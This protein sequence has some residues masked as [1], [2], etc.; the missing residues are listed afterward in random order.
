MT[1]DPL[2]YPI[3]KFDCP[4]NITSEKLEAWISILEHFPERLA[5]LVGNLSEEQLNTRYRPEGW[6]IRQVVHH[7]YDSHHHSY[8]RYKWALTEDTPLIKAYDEAKWAEVFDYVTTP[9]EMS[10]QALSALHRKL[11]FLLKGMK[12]EDFQREYIHPE[13]PNN[14]S[15]A[16]NT[17]IYAWHCNHHYTHIEN[18]MKQKGWK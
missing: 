13:K 18:I 9:I 15:L 3:G 10:L 5:N 12:S 4:S 6:T 14:V 16:E 8:V 7:V 2:K 17:G 11:V 1:L